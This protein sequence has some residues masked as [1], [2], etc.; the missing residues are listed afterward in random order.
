M[1]GL[2]SSFRRDN[3]ALIKE[4][5]DVK[6]H[7]LKQFLED[8]ITEAGKITLEY[9]DRI[10]TVRIDRKSDKDLVTEADVAV[11]KF[12]I[13]KIKTRYPDHAI[14]GEESG[15]HAG[16]QYRW[17][18][19]PIDGTTGFVHGQ[20]F[21]SVS[22]CVEKDGQFVLG[23]VYAPVLSELF[24]AEKGKGATLNGKPIRCTQTDEL[25]DAMLGTGFACIRNNLEHNNLPYFNT[26]MPQI[27]GIRRFGSAA[28]D[29]SYVACGRLDG[30][31]ELNLNVYDVAAGCLILTEAGGKYSDFLGGTKN[32]YGQFL[33]SNGKLHDKVVK[34][35]RG[36]YEGR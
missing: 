31:W 4:N 1:F 8:I 3:L 21:Y 19:D 18:I 33:A 27:Q 6:E 13:D 12:L 16:S 5:L 7:I 23:A 17:I 35:L 32:L 10:E 30:F 29:L 34:V 2:T 14:I 26:L 24:Q 15:S 22:I 28:V 9:R 25:I 20:P 36:V 11:E